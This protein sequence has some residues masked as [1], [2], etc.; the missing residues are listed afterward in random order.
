MKNLFTLVLILLGFSIN[1]QELDGVP[2]SQESQSFIQV[3]ASNQVEINKLV[4][5][6]EVLK[7]IAFVVIA[8][9]CVAY[10]YIYKG[11]IL[12]KKMIDTEKSITS[13]NSVFA[14]TSGA[15]IFLYHLGSS[16]QTKALKLMNR[17]NIAI[18]P[19]EHGLGLVYNF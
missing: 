7:T 10:A 2:T 13:L 8:G 4:N 16:K 1:A 6:A 5:Q 19:T 18:Y 14:L 17:Q 3:S 9:N 15:S 11:I 12:P